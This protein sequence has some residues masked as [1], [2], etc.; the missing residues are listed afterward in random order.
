MLISRS[1]RSS[2]APPPGYQRIDTEFGT[3]TATPEHP[4]WVQG[5]GWTEAK[6]LEWEDPIATLEGDVV[7]YA[8]TYVEEPTQVYN[9]SVANTPNY[10]AGEAKAWVHNANCNITPE[11][12]DLLVDGNVPGV[13][14]G[15]FS[16]WFNNLN[17]QELDIL[18][19]D[20]SI[21]SKIEARIRQP[22]G[23]HEWCMACRAPT[24]KRWGVSMEEIKE[25]RS[26]ISELTWV[27]PDTGVSGV[28]G[29]DRSGQ[30]H[31]ELKHIIDNRNS[32]DEFNSDINNLIER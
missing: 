15:A 31:N 7:A 21:R 2:A 18:W 25:F 5:K 4:F 30:F 11:I 12:D 13:R 26:V 27:H 16:E 19:Q 3:L 17:V 28:H 10:F 22:G 24:F 29:K 14:N 1:F 23:L 8:N 32:L 20:D 9:F 6:D